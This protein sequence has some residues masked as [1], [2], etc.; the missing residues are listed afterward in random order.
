MTEQLTLWL[1]IYGTDINHPTANVISKPVNSVWVDRNQCSEFW[2]SLPTG[3]PGLIPGLR[4]S[5]GEGNG[6]PFQY[7]C[8][9][10]SMDRGAWRAAVHGVTKSRTHLGHKPIT[11]KM[12]K[13]KDKHFPYLLC[14][15]MFHNNWIVDKSSLQKNSNS[16]QMPM[17][18]WIYE[19]NML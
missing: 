11:L 18:C 5:F 17:E 10:I 1:S 19:I 3:G 2:S 6:N 15:N 7:F 13:E 16:L 9:G 8:L 4:R 14:I 12:Y